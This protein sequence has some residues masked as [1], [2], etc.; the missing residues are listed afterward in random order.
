MLKPVHRPNPWT[1]GTLCLLYGFTS[2]LQEGNYRAQLGRVST[3]VLN[4]KT[5]TIYVILKKN[6]NQ[7]RIMP[8]AFLHSQNHCPQEPFRN[9]LSA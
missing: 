5:I 8:Q 3:K 4:P 2:E 6:N 7:Y 1:I 9:G